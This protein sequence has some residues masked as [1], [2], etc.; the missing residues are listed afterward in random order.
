MM[1]KKHY[2][3]FCLLAIK[4][5]TQVAISTNPSDHDPH[6]NAILDVKSTTPAKAVLLPSVSQISNAVNPVGDNTFNGALV[7]SK[8]NASIYEHD[9]TRWRST[10][11]YVVETKPQYLAHFS[12]PNT[13]PAISCTAY[14]PLSC[15]TEVVLPLVNTNSADFTGNLINLS[16]SNNTITINETGLYRVTYRANAI[17]DGVNPSNT[18]P[19]VSDL[20]MRLQKANAATPTAFS[21]IDYQSSP[22]D[23][24]YNPV[25]NGSIVLKMNVGDK[26]RL[27]GYIQSNT[28]G[29]QVFGMNVSAHI[30]NNAEVVF[31][32]IVL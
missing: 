32:K 28:N 5:Y 2:L 12:A 8:N 11:D 16:L 25:F 29:I 17:F 13:M 30:Q 18:N 21:V 20:Q 4:G 22:N 24:A 15:N 10:Y 7:Y 19:L 1:K 23:T 27:T 31:E 6:P 26:I 3:L 14:I 9:G